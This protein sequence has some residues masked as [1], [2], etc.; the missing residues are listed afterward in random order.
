MKANTAIKGKEVI[1][2]VH[3]DPGSGAEV[4]EVLGQAKI[5]VIAMV[6]YGSMVSEETAWM[7]MLCDNPVAAK[8]A[9]QGKG[10]SVELN[11]V[12]L[13]SMVNLPGQMANVLNKAGAKKVNVDYSYGAAI[14]RS[15]ITVLATPN[16]VKAY[17]A[18]NA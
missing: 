7:H 18:I 8:R 5:N 10:Y 9:L 13:I 4:L 2:E 3:N 1:V 6:G 15:G 16:L 11:S 14:G 12:L 17:N